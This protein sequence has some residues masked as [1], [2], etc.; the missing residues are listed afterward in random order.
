[1]SY[2]SAPVAAGTHTI[3]IT[4]ETGSLPALDSFAVLG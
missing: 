3:E 4:T 1:M 2:V